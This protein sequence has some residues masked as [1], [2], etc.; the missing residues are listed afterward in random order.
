MR[1]TTL[2]LLPG[3]ALVGGPEGYYS[4]GWKPPEI[5]GLSRSSEEGNLGGGTVEIDGSGFGD[6]AAQLVVLF[7]SHNATVVEASDSRLTVTV[8]GGPITGG[9]VPVTV[10]TKTGYASAP[11]PY[12]YDVGPVGEGQVGFV[13]IN[14]YWE[15]CYGGLS[16]RLDDEWA[17]YGGLGCDTIAY[18]G[19][20][21]IDG[22]ADRLSFAYPRLHTETVGFFPATDQGN[23]EW[24]IERPGQVSFSFG[25]DDLHKDIGPVTLHNSF[26]EDEAGV[27]TDVDDL[28]AYRYG[29]GAEDY[30][31]PFS[32]QSAFV[33]ATLNADDPD[34]CAEN[35]GL[36]YDS[37]Q[38]E[39]CTSDDVDG[40]PLWTYEADWPVVRN[41][42]QSHN[43]Q[44]NPVTISMDAPEVGI[45]GQ[46]LSLPEPLVV[47]NI[48]GVTPIA[49]DQETAGD[50]WA[51]LPL[52]GC[53]D[54]EDNGENLDD[55]A[56]EFTWLPSDVSYT[57]GGA[58]LESQTYVRVTLT[59]L[60]LNWFGTTGYPARA[61]LTV[62]DVHERDRDGFSHIEIPAEVLYQLPTVVTPEDSPDPLV[63]SYDPNWG[64]LLI[65]FDRVTEYSLAATAGEGDNAKSIGNV[66]FSYSTGDFGFTGWKNPADGD[67]CH[68]C[69]DDDEDGWTDAED[70]DCAEG[71]EETGFGDAACNDGRDNDRDGLT[72]AEDDLCLTA[73][74]EDESNCSNNRD[75]DR[76]GYVDA[77]DP[78]CAA[79]RNE[80]S[81][82][83]PCSNGDDDDG[84]GWVDEADPDCAAGEDELGYGTGECNDGLDNDDD[85]LVDAA[86][87]ECV[88]ALGTEAA[89][90]PTSCVDGEDDDGDGWTDAADPDCAE[91]DVE[92]GYGTSA[93]NDGLDNDKDLAADAD[94][95]DCADAA[96]DD[97][98]L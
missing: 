92:A 23:A 79:G 31:E 78:E 95:L 15:S 83:R 42:F 96:D 10:A 30:N 76:D 74:D 48:Q 50:L 71:L 56:L 40:L 9:E 82:D 77:D 3:C 39:F 1:L 65:T 12:L 24:F 46:E 45:V 29:G 36:W 2:L 75:D 14:N 28:A 44:L 35:G 17:D 66:V 20:V 49:S 81:D 87:P 7:G 93:C 21:G 33:P 86:D 90:A 98:A 89:P 53:F 63:D 47:Y 52:E 55:I 27:C 13:Q 34:R 73:T 41:F 62:P 25:I 58:V 88:D 60:S 43:R 5:S 16:S 4:T 32:V 94:D 69:L 67:A 18:I 84:D 59:A 61:V 91:G 68:N 37:S 22:R 57:E 64:Y 11:E 85:T 54:D 97:E 70:P 72:D 6:D 80:L 38:M 26:W 19:Y 51:L 8:P